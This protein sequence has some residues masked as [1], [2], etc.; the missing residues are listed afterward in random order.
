MKRGK[1]MR[2]T[3]ITFDQIMSHVLFVSCVQAVLDASATKS[4]ILHEPI[5]DYNGLMSFSEAVAT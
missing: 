1:K 4:C 3:I 2:M 5:K